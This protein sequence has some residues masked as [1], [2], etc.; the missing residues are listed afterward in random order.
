MH[1]AESE[2]TMKTYES[3]TKDVTSDHPLRSSGSVR[4]CG[5][6]NPDTKSHWQIQ[7]NS[8]RKTKGAKTT[9][10]PQMTTNEA[11][12]TK[13]RAELVTLKDARVSPNAKE[14]QEAADLEYESQL[15][16]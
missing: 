5:V 13:P 6:Q 14:W 4:L 3:E 8:V 10:L 16:N 2:I 1:C 15:E 12:K 7:L 11:K 9:G